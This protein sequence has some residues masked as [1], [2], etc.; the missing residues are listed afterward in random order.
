MTSIARSK[1][2]ETAENATYQS[3]K[4]CEATELDESKCFKKSYDVHDL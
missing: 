2:P 3:I 4:S 1:V